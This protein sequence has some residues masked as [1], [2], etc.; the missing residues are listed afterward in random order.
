[1]GEKSK[2]LFTHTQ[3]FP[4]I[5]SRGEMVTEA[6]TRA[7]IAVKAARKS[8]GGKNYKVRN[9]T[10]FVNAPT[11]REKKVKHE[12]YRAHAVP[13]HRTDANVLKRSFTSD[14]ATNCLRMNTIVCEVDIKA[15][16]PM[17]KDACEKVFGV[18]PLKVNT[19]ITPK[20]VKKA[21]IKFPRSV[22][23]MDLARKFKIL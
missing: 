10:R 21:Y 6:A 7:Q 12:K 18:K 17:I 23:A 3:A 1:M 4:T 8:H 5:T 15:N 20:L 9:V 22:E 19:L 13:K 14:K 2:N 11:L 16:K